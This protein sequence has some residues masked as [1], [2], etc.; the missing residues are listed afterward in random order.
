MEQDKEQWEYDVRPM[1]P[2]F[3]SSATAIS[4][5][6]ETLIDWVNASCCW[7]RYSKVSSICIENYSGNSAF[8]AWQN[9]FL[10]KKR[11]GNNNGL[12]AGNCLFLCLSTA[13]GALKPSFLFFL[14]SL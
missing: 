14:F 4:L 9:I 1:L 7:A 10:F 2:F 3:A 13:E 8:D 6:F 5:I 11:A 12:L